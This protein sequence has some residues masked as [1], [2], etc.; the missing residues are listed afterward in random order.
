MY[1]KL[2][3]NHEL[4]SRKFYKVIKYNQ[5]AWLGSYIDMNTDL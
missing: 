5:N 2:A 3:L 4:F 1:L